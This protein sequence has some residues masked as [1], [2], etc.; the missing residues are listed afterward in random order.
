ML[1]GTTSIMFYSLDSPNTKKLKKTGFSLVSV[2]KMNRT[3]RTIK[4]I[5]ENK[6]CEICAAAQCAPQQN[7]EITRFAAS[8]FPPMRKCIENLV[9]C[10][11]YILL[12][13]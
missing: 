13:Q 5:Y 12:Q 2:Y 4:D 8:F 6:Q 11:K 7:G 10:N 9:D 1:N 3:L